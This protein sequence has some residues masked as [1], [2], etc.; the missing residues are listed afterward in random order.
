MGA[1]IVA[2]ELEW[3]SG[4]KWKSGNEERLDVGM[5]EKRIRKGWKLE[6]KREDK[7]SLEWMRE[8]M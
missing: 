8:W 1:G 3:M 7:K 2:W 5:N 6:W 4:P